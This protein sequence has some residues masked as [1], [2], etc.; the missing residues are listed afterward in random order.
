MLDLVAATGFTSAFIV[1][2]AYVNIRYKWLGFYA[3]SKE[4]DSPLLNQQLSSGGMT[5]AGNARP[6]PQVQIGIPEVSP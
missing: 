1:Q 3:G 5:W 2:Q 4:L 6:I